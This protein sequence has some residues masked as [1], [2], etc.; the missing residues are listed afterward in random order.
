MWHKVVSKYYLYDKRAD[1]CIRQLSCYIPSNFGVSRLI[2]G[3]LSSS[4][5]NAGFRIISRASTF[6]HL[7]HRL[8][9]LCHSLIARTIYGIY[10]LLAGTSIKPLYIVA[11]NQVGHGSIVLT[12]HANLILRPVALES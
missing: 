12:N 2:Y 6:F 1:H 5:K 10:V 3:T 8:G 4:H 9:G 7:S 11:S